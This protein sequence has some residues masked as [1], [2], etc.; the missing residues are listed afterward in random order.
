MMNKVYTFVC[1]IVLQN[2]IIVQA[3]EPTRSIRSDLLSGISWPEYKQ[4]LEGTVQAQIDALPEKLRNDESI[5]QAITWVLKPRCYLNGDWQEGRYMG[6][7]GFFDCSEQIFKTLDIKVPAS[8]I[9]KFYHLDKVIVHRYPQ[10]DTLIV[11][12]GNL[13]LPLPGITVQFVEDHDGFQNRYQYIADHE[14]KDCDTIDPDFARNPTIVGAFGI[15][16][17]TNVFNDHTYKKIILEG[18]QVEHLPFSLKLLINLLDED[19]VV[20]DFSAFNP[21]GQYGDISYSPTYSRRKLI[22]YDARKKI[23]DGKYDEVKND[24]YM[25]IEKSGFNDQFEGMNQSFAVFNYLV[26]RGLI[27]EAEEAADYFSKSPDQEI[28][29]EAQKLA[30]KIST[31]KISQ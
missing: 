18:I 3:G 15:N 9:R 16:D 28:Q 14:H 4:M 31:A 13:L 8:S 1:L 22:A 6:F 23:F 26:D 7:K 5:T 2:I 30:G 17:I 21:G 20:E 10:H 19:G 27:R 24:L 25:L 12:C 29:I 11:G